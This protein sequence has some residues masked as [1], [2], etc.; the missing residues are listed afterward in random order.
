[1]DIRFAVDIVTLK[2]LIGL[3]VTDHE[4]E[5]MAQDARLI[6]SHLSSSG[7]DLSDSPT[8]QFLEALTKL[9]V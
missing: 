1:M 5:V 9:P 3:K 4:L 8:I 2:N 7:A 6:M